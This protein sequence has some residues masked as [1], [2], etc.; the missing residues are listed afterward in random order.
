VPRTF[1]PLSH[2]ETGGDRLLEKI[3][4]CQRLDKIRMTYVYVHANHSTYYFGFS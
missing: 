3:L 1:R 2:E 4:L